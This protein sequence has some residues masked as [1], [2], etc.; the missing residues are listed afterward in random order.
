M[1]K[2]RTRIYYKLQDSNHQ[3]FWDFVQMESS[4]L[5]AYCLANP[6]EKVAKVWGDSWVK[7][8]VHVSQGWTG[9]QLHRDEHGPFERAQVRK[10]SRWKRVQPWVIIGRGIGT[11]E[12]AK[13]NLR[14][15]K[16]DKMF[17]PHQSDFD[18][19]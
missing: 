16:L 5:F 4:H 8:E 19:C 11:F 10:R 3:V 14:Q 2:I 6:Q 7:E 15:E 18:L 13:V 12:V 17:I 1:Q 9:E